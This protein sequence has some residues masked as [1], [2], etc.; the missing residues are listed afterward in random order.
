MTKNHADLRDALFESSEYLSDVLT[1]CAFIEKNFY[2]DSNFSTKDG[3][4]NA[5][6]RLYRTVLLYTV[7]IRRAQDPS[8]GR[9]VQDLFTAITGHPL[10]ELKD[11]VT[12]ERE[13]I[14]K[15]IELVQHLHREKEAENILTEI[16]NLAE[17]VKHLIEQFGLVNLRVAEGAFYNSFI[18]GQEDFCLLD[19]R[20][21]LQ[22]R[23]S[24]WADS[25]AGQC[26]F[27]LKGMAG[28]GKSTIARTVARSFEKKGQ[29]GATFFFKRG[30]ADRFGTGEAKPNY[31]AKHF[32]STITSQLAARHQQ[33]V[34]DILNAIE[35]DPNISFKSLSEQF[36]KLLFQPLLKLHLNQPTTTVIVIDALDEC[37]R[38]DDIE[39]ILQLLPR[40]Q[41]SQSVRLRIFLTSRPELPVR[42]G[43]GQD[44]NHQEVAL[45]GLPNPVIEHDIRLFL[46]YKFSAIQKKRSLPLHWPGNENLER[47]VKMAVPSFIFAATICRFVGDR[48]WRPEKRLEAILEDPTASSG[49]EIERTY[50]P[51]LNQL[52]S[53]TNEG[54]A[55]QLVQEFQDIVGVVI[56]L[57]T[58]L[59]VN[60]LSQLINLPREDV[61]N[62]LDGFHSVLNIPEDV[63]S[64]IR[65]LHLSF[66]DFLVKTTSRFHV[67]E[68]ETHRK[69]ALHCFRV[70]NDRLKRNI[71]GLSSYGTEKVDIDNQTLD[72]H[73][74]ADVQYS[75]RYWV[76]HL[77]HSRCDISE[78]PVLSFFKTNLLHWLEAL[79]LMNVLSEAVGMMDMLQAVAM[80]GLFTF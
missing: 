77:Q 13:N 25:T 37:D 27:W 75:C 1:Q 12:E 67:N 33:L 17:S 9:R 53:G 56:L 47:L 3:L 14:S 66:R 40:L 58:P 52:L 15:W 45:H 20:T 10:K 11:S 68:A 24:G 36:E 42:L 48:R 23:V 29:L 38:E 30:E 32:I 65:L 55:K 70:L 63:D 2:S 4:A 69:I 59:S 19:T 5:L 44:N 16:D 39:V 71:C 31:N 74:P 73:I 80:V 79:S 57:A 18:N 28:T 54:D 35:N 41:N 43:F 51:V 34:P 61:R 49:S 7:Q 60:A 22:S 72:Q 6:V 46:E 78:F 50:S 64:P 21:E 26:I 8:A 62:R 76:H